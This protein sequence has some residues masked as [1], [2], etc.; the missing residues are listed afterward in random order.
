MVETTVSRAAWNLREYTA[1]SGRYW[2]F[3]RPQLA[4]GEMLVEA[5]DIEWK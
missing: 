2:S 5:A 1:N 4:S 3:E